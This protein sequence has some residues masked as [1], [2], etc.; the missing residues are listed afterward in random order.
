[1]VTS[2]H[3]KV[4]VCMSLSVWGCVIWAIVETVVKAENYSVRFNVAM[5]CIGVDVLGFLWLFVVL[6]VQYIGDNNEV[7][8]TTLNQGLTEACVR[9]VTGTP[10]VPPWLLV[11]VQ[12]DDPVH[13]SD[14][15]EFRC[16]GTS[17][18]RRDD[19]R[20]QCPNDNHQSWM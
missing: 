11:E 12:V 20:V 15:S 13:K 19:G 16:D 8:S 18:S 2:H 3:L 10:L 1:M 4:G 6:F 7:R 14:V 5:A 9:P 17:T